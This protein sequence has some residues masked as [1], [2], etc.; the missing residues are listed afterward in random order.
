MNSV[1]LIQ[2]VLHVFYEHCVFADWIIVCFQSHNY[3]KYLD[4]SHCAFNIKEKCCPHWSFHPCVITVTECTLN[5]T[6]LPCQEQW[7]LCVSC[8]ILSVLPIWWEYLYVT[9][10]LSVT[11][12]INNVFSGW[13]WERNIITLMDRVVLLQVSTDYHLL[14]YNHY[15]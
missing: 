11:G 8:T 6:L 4:Q 1:V 15:L 7:N 5:A 14:F 13:E 12:A 9:C 3:D 2:E 10:S